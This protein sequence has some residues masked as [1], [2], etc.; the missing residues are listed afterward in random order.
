MYKAETEWSPTSIANRWLQLYFELEH[1]EV[2]TTPTFYDVN[3]CALDSSL[4]SFRISFLGYYQSLAYTPQLAIVPFF[5]P[6]LVFLI[7]RH[8]GW[9]VDGCCHICIHGPKIKGSMKIYKGSMSL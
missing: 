7:V 9:T 8:N 5:S 1:S 4:S 3:K 6:K 2:L